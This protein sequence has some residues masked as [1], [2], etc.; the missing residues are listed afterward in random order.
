[1]LVLCVL[2]P[3]QNLDLLLYCGVC[4]EGWGKIGLRK[5]GGGLFEPLSWTPP[6]FW[7]HVMGAPDGLMVTP[8]RL[9]GEVR[10]GS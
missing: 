8:N 2:D 1:M 4:W 7:A 9:T 5:G 6:P 10:G 3:P